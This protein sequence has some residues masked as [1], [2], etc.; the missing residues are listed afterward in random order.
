M[1]LDANIVKNILSIE[2]LS[3]I[4]GPY[5]EHKSILSLTKV[6]KSITSRKWE[7]ICLEEINNITGYLSVEHSDEYNLFWN[8]LVKEIKEDV[9]PQI[10]S[11]LEMLLSSGKITESIVDSVL[12]DMVNIV[13]SFTYSTY[14]SSEFY[15]K[16]Y[17]VYSNGHL[18][19]G[20][21]GKYPEGQIEVY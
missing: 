9:I 20:W 8:Q 5:D 11:Q 16:M 6:N 15:V 10:K 4:G 18:P 19:Y 1:K 13:M 17:E 14:I 2:L 7:N 12:F 21:K 3:N